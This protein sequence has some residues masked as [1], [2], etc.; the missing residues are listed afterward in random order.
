MNNIHTCFSIFFSISKGICQDKKQ[1]TLHI[2]FKMVLVYPT[3]L[4]CECI[5][6]TY[7]FSTNQD[8]LRKTY[9][10]LYLETFHILTKYLHSLLIWISVCVK[11]QHFSDMTY[12]FAVFLYISQYSKFTLK[13]PG[14]QNKKT[15]L[16]PNRF[17]I[18]DSK[19]YGLSLSNKIHYYLNPKF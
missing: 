19:L 17:L 18:C 14:E 10:I 9:F 7:I 11:T 6:V 2:G 16:M 4:W 5:N 1:E 3:F 13:F 15:T 12:L 8:K